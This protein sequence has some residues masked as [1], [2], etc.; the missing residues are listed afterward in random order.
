MPATPDQIKHLLSRTGVRVVA[1]RLAQLTQVELA[2]AVDMV[3]D[4]SANPALV[5]PPVPSSNDTAWMRGV[6]NDWMDR[7]ANLPNPL[8]AKLVLFWHGHFANSNGKVGSAPFMV[9]QYQTISQY[10]DGP[11]ESLAQ[12]LAL[13]P[14]ML[15]YLDNRSN[16]RRSP[17]ENFAR[18]LL[19]LFTLGDGRGYTEQDVVEV[20][21]AWTGYGL[22]SD[23]TTFAFNAGNH[24]T[25]NKTIFGIT[26]AWRGPEVITEICAGTRRRT[27]AEYLARKLWEFFAY[28]NSDASLLSSLADD[29]EAEGM[30]TLNFLRRMFKR[31][32]F[33]SPQS[34][35]G[36]VKSP[37]EWV[38]SVIG[39]VGLGAASID[40]ASA[41][42][43]AGHEFFYPPGVDGWKLNEVWINE[44]T[45]WALDRFAR[46]TAYNA[47]DNPNLAPTARALLQS[48]PTLSVTAAVTAVADLFGLTLSAGTRQALEV[49][50]T[51]MR[52]QNRPRQGGQLVRLMSMTTEARLA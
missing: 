24:D 4:F 50:L 38:A 13:D 23:S 16:V 11:F 44:T 31:V 8:H 35:Q 21:R 52:G 27:C 32:E 47:G 29:M 49:W 19:E 14:A 41:T 7:L 37:M 48:V 46:A 3:C 1:S 36:R 25:G 43:T 22:N 2:Q 5:V 45:T 17:N 20:A 26:R 6:R 39:S 15:V 40:A 33:Y 30:H 12:A 28:E 42:I 34:M 51:G 18:E 9:Q 10:A